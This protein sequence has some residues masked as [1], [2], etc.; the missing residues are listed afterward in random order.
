MNA[1]PPDVQ[2]PG[3]A[4]EPDDNQG[5]GAAAGGQRHRPHVHEAGAPA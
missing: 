3:A 2:H 5:G 1:L 4:D